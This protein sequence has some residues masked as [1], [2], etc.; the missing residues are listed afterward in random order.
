MEVKVK[1]LLLSLC[2][3]NLFFFVLMVYFDNYPLALM[4][5]VSVIVTA[6]AAGLSE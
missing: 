1:F 6:F 4:N 5:F 3:I 2:V